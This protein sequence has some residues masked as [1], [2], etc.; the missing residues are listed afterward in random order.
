[1]VLT[2]WFVHPNFPCRGK[3]EINNINL[4]IF[5]PLRNLSKKKQKTTRLLYIGYSGSKEIDVMNWKV[6]RM[7]L[8][9][10]FVPP[11]NT[12]GKTNENS[13]LTGFNISNKNQYFIVLFQIKNCFQMKDIFISFQNLFKRNT[14]PHSKL[15]FFSFFN[16]F[17]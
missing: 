17:L 1:M 13:L 16:L 15:L 2:F 10:W 11:K 9:T 6:K 12:F 14:T 7:I 5:F 3:Q 4:K 8:T